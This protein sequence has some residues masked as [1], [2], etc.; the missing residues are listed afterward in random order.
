MNDTNY[1]DSQLLDTLVAALRA[2]TQ[3]WCLPTDV[4]RMYIAPP[5]RVSYT[6]VLVIELR[7]QQ[8]EG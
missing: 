7:E 2:G 8:K 4:E 3:A 6:P 1:P 5:D